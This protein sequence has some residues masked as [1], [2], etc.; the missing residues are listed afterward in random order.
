MQAATFVEGFRLSPQ[1]RRLW[2][3]QQDAT[4]Q[5]FG[6]LLVLSLEG[7]LRTDALRKALEKVCIRHESLRTTF[8]RVPGVAM[9]V[10]SVEGVLSPS[11]RTIDL[12]DLVGS[13]Q[14]DEVEALLALECRRTF[15]YENGPLVHATLMALSP[16]RHLLSV[17]L[18]TLCS[19]RCTLSNLDRDLS[20]C[21]AEMIGGPDVDD[22]PLQYSQFSEW[23]NSL[24]EDE[25]AVKGKEYWS[26]Q[27]L[28]NTSAVLPG[29]R[30]RPPGRAEIPCARQSVR[31]SLSPQYANRITALAEK[32]ESTTATV[33]LAAWQTL[34]WRLTEQ[35]IV[36]GNVCDGRSYELLHDA[37]GLFARVLPLC[38]Q[39]TDG[40]RFDE[41]IAQIDKFQRESEEWQDYF[42]LDQ[43]T[44]GPL[45]HFAFGYEYADLPVARQVAGLQVSVSD[46]HCDSEPFA[47]KLLCVSK[48]DGVG[49]TF[50]YTSDAFD[51]AY[52][53]HLAEQFQTL[54]TA[55]LDN[56]ETSIEE[57][58]I[59][60]AAEQ[61]QVVFAWNNAKR[62]YPSD[63]SVAQLFEQQVERTPDALAAVF[64]D[65]RLT[66]AE[67]NRRANQLARYLQAQGVSAEIPVGICL[68]PSLEMLIAVL[69]VLKAGGAYLPLDPRNP[70]QRIDQVLSDA[71][72]SVLLTGLTR[73]TSERTDNLQTEVAPENLAYI[74]YTSGSTGQPKGVMVQHRSVVNLAAALH[75]EVYTDP[76]P[77]LKV[78]LS[79]PLAFDASVKQLVQLLRGHTLYLLP[80]ELR[81][82]ATGA[83]AYL[84]QHQLDVL[85]CT[86]SQLKLLLAAGFNQHTTPRLMLVGG[87]ALD[88]STWSRLAED[89]QTRFFNVY[90][91]TE[92][93]VDATWAPVTAELPTVGRPIPNAEIYILD[94]N[95]KPVGI[96][97]AGELHI[98]GSG[99][100]RGYLNA[101][102]KTAERFIPD[103]LSGQT[104]A[105]LYRTG[106]L[107]RYSPDG[108]IV[109]VGRNDAQIKVRGHRI[110]LGEIE[111]ALRQHERVRQAVVVARES[112]NA[113]VRLVGYV[114]AESGQTIEVGELRRMLSERL[115]DYMLPSF[116]VVIDE[117]PLTRNGKIDLKALPAPEAL[118][119][120]QHEH[121]VAPRNEIEATITRVWQE[122]LGV[123]RIGVND[124][125][126][127]A[128]GHSLLMVQVHNKLS[129]LFEKNISIVE[130]FA[131]PTIGA[132]AEYFSE[133][134]G[135]K[136]TFDKVMDRAARRR[137]AVSVRQ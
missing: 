128:G 130:M 111:S 126:F 51:E 64:Q 57:L 32:C 66:F 60:S 103:G 50:D 5:S 120:A 38:C 30:V 40:L 39:F 56:P 84:D 34:L 112:N 104:G 16:Q 1:Q 17:G 121:Y 122:V 44:E 85:D 29:Q 107:A 27:D 4:A 10:Q 15:D 102:D 106:D 125:F 98:G 71:A 25:D 119:P 89:Q 79:A 109:F 24:W 41:V 78:G 92:C 127:D 83:L 95:L 137:Q 131:K 45:K 22:E 117:L 105:R 100:A 114:V 21:Y 9:P 118:R 77:S 47:L 123:E 115:P 67:L 54:L 49:L 134:N 113:G 37:F 63:K 124:N 132:L 6:S 2:K 62:D 28:S 91:P 61:Q 96:H 136:P 55:A 97:L 81:L 13:L 36:I 12:S 7:E 42:D 90:G 133:T 26:K 14:S 8:Q 80:E 48:A 69:G 70:Q 11:W 58:E 82:D 108:S 72:A 129:E 110:E 18:P 135:H 88:D 23:Q 86:P 94:K 52:V 3:L 46:Q 65:Q 101:P 19:D 20:G 33:L 99:L 31:V 75:E 73:V 116:L 74:I 87:E 68:E 76:G 53:R 59:V 43:S 35:S 93:T